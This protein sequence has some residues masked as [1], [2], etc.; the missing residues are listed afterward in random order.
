VFLWSNEDNSKRSHINEFSVYV[1]AAVLAGAI[2]LV[3][4]FVPLP[5]AYYPEF[6]VSRPAEVIPALFFFGAW[7]GYLRLGEW[8][9]EPFQYWLLISLMISCFVHAMYM[10]QAT[11]EFDGIA[12]AA[13]F[14]NIMAN[15]SV[16]AGLM[17][18]VFVTFRSET[19]A[20]ETVRQTNL[21]MAREVKVRA[22]AEYR[23]RD[24]F[25]NANDLI[26]ITDAQGSLAYVNRA[27]AATFW[28]EQSAVDGQN[29][30][31]L[32]HPSNRAELKEAFRRLTEGGS[33]E[34]FISELYT[35]DGEPVICAISANYSPVYG[36]AV[37]AE[38]ELASSRANLNAWSRIPVT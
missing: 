38:R 30:Y 13:H 18:S 19:T 2:F 10:L 31:T 27:W 15:V 23:L 28:Y 29:M 20:L 1:A 36:E 14:L 25:D 5:S 9:I 12:D 3:F 37:I 24:F 17:I 26:Q 11:S 4:R 22:Q 21:A 33:M 32:L 16:L 8:R 35:R 34:R 6:W 7:V